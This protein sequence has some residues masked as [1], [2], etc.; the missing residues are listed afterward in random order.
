MPVMNG[1]EAARELQ[2]T[3]PRVPILMFTTF[4]NAFVEKEALASGV[5]AV[6]S[7]SDS[8]DRLFETVQQLLNSPAKGAPS[9]SRDIA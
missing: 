9:L 5:S 7:K 8:M 3:M 6:Q 2:K 1:F 4:C